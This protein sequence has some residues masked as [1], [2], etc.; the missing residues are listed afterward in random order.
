MRGRRFAMMSCRDGGNTTAE[1]SERETVPTALRGSA[2]PLEVPRASGSA[3][4]LEVPRAAAAAVVLPLPV[5]V[6]VA[7]MRGI[8]FETE[9]PPLASS[10]AA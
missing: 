1:G 3:L 2:P 9:A 8:D 7:G 6:R 5:P 10:S 4:P